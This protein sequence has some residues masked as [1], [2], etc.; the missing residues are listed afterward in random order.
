MFVV[1]A[2]RYPDLEG[3]LREAV[4]SIKN[5]ISERQSSGNPASFLDI[6][7][8]ILKHTAGLIVEA[9]QMAPQ[10]QAN[11]WKDVG[12]LSFDVLWDEIV[13]QHNFEVIPDWIEPTAK[14]LFYEL[15]RNLLSY[16][17]DILISRLTIQSLG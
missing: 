16:S 8:L 14:S 13:Q 15:V 2:S 3:K 1:F 6:A 11:D 7:K 12:L 4:E 9:I 17:I 5:L 10:L